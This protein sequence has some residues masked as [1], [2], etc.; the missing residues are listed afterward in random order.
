VEGLAAASGL[1]AGAAG[2]YGEFPPLNGDGRT[3]LAV[4]LVL[5]ALLLAAFVATYIWFDRRTRRRIL[6][7]RWELFRRMCRDRA[8]AREEVVALRGLQQRAVPDRPH[9]LVTSL[10]FY[11]GA[12]EEELRRLEADGTPFEERS[13][14]ANTFVNVREKLFFGEAMAKARVESTLDLEPHQAL[15]VEIP[16]R[17]GTYSSSV[18]SVNDSSLTVAVPTRRG[19]PVELRRGDRVIV[20]LSVRNDAGYRFESGVAGIR[21]GRVPA[22]HLWHTEKL[23]R[24]QLRTW[25]RMSVE[26]PAR[27]HRISFP[28]LQPEGEQLVPPEKYATA[29]HEG[30]YTGM[31]RD[32]SLGGVCLRCEE[33]FRK[34][35]YAGVLVP[36]FGPEGDQPEEEIEILGRVVDCRE[37]ET[38]RNKLYNMHVQFVPLD[39]DTRSVLMA[40]MF[41]LQRRL[42]RKR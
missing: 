30:L 26:V 18:V 8:L 23:E 24:Q 20:Y 41:Q 21:E 2:G 36:I 35:E 12:V 1:L 4:V 3:G 27:F 5:G 25:M 13:D 11:D 28:D 29:R 39:D 40:N 37:L 38:I 33:P 16:G 42:G 17:H 34:G 6:E 14:A 15:R 9:L 7:E 32:F 10:N 22:V 19:E 31:M